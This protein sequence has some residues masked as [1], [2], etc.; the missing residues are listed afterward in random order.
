MLSSA[1]LYLRYTGISFKSQMQYKLSFFMMSF[2]HFMVTGIEILGIL[3]LFSRFKSLG[4]WNLAQVALFYGLINIS[5][6]IAEAFGRGF[7]TFS[8]LV[9]SGDFDRLLLR[10]RTTALQVASSDIQLMRIGRLLQGL[11]VLLWAAGALDVAWTFPKVFLLL[12][13]IFSG[14]CLFMGLFVI[15]ATISFWSIE[16]LEL[17]NTV[18][19]G[20]TEAGQYPISIYQPWF[21]KF[22]TFVVPIACFTYF[23]ILAILNKQDS[24][25]H[26]PAWFQWTAPI[27]GFVFLLVTLRI[28]RFGERH[29]RS[30][31]S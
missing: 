8:D 2:G 19:Y 7:D 27:C 9:K 17:M 15:Q 31:G 3:V 1:Q 6:A 16:T 24:V 13:A 4:E 5:F 29:Y 30:T 25:M 20:G 28:W 18:T 10:P 11:I 12:F 21:R 26:S 22:F 14:V 23:P